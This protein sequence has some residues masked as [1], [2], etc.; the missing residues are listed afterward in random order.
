M[1][2]KKKKKKRDKPHPGEEGDFTD[3]QRGIPGLAIS[4]Y[5]PTNRTLEP[6]VVE[7]QPSVQSKVYV[8]NMTVDVLPHMKRGHAFLKYGKYGY[9]HFRLVQLSHDNLDICWYTKHKR[10]K[11]SKV[12]LNLVDKL[13]LGQATSN[14]ARHPTPELARHSFSLLYGKKTLDLIAKDSNEYE[15]WTRGLEKLLELLEKENSKHL[16]ALKALPCLVRIRNRGYLDIVDFN[17]GTSA[18][19]LF[20]SIEE[21]QNSLKSPYI[22]QDR[23]LANKVKA[24]AKKVEALSIQLRTE[25]YQLS[26][27]YQ[28]MDDMMKQIERSV[29]KMDTLLE[30]EDFRKVSDELWRAGVDFKALRYM[31]KTIG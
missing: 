1:G 18:T 3:I 7:L 16:V 14:F 28:S 6:E 29:E 30:E 31:M 23:K 22:T 13:Q 2:K 24:F 5:Q 4:P 10:S 17:T 12:P 9:P 21:K 11:D 15:M 25:K 20:G 27:S 8:T 19:T 26:K